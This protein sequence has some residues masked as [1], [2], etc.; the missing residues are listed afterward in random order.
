VEGEVDEVME[1]NYRKMLRRDWREGLGGRICE[2]ES[3]KWWW[4]VG[5]EK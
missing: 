1:E 5:G 4:G 2:K 3:W